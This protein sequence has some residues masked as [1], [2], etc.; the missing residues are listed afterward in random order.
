MDINKFTLLINESELDNVIPIVYDEDV[1]IDR[2]WLIK[3]ESQSYLLKSNDN[4]CIDFKVL[5]LDTF[6]LNK[7][8]CN[9]TLRLTG[10]LQSL[11]IDYEK[12]NI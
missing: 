2:I 8:N 7:I 5:H 1:L 10:I 6:E 4:K 11:G 9:L 12:T 3:L